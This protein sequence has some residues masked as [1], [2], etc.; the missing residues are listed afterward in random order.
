MEL[1]KTWEDHFPPEIIERYDVRETRSAAAIMNVTTPEAFQDMLDVL[2]SC[3]I[4]LAQLTKKGGNKSDIAKMLDDAF[5]QKGWR[6][7]KY[8]QQVTTSLISSPWTA[9][10]EKATS[11]STFENSF[12]GHKVDNVK[13]RAALDVE[14]NPKDGNL[15]RDFANYVALHEAG[16]IDVGVIICR[17][18]SLQPFTRDLIAQVKAVEVPAKFTEWHK[19]MNGLPDD[20][21]GTSTTANFEKLAPRLERGDGRG[22]PILAIGVREESYTPP[23]NNVDTEVLRIAE[24]LQDG[25]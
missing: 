10:G 13:G 3:S 12:G 11:T 1:T 5:R 16:A 18:A 9:I 22:C 20:P 2:E 17:G 4:T 21:F 15:D 24:E 7:T 14:W 8:E 19:R 23:Q 25:A 6:E